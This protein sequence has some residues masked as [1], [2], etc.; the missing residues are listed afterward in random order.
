[1]IYLLQTASPL[2]LEHDSVIYFRIAMGLLNVA[3][4]PSTGYPVGYPALLAALDRA[5]ISSPA[6][7][8]LT[9]CI[10]IAMGLA[11]LSMLFPNARRVTR[12][13]IIILSL[14]SYPMIRSAAMPLTEAAYFGVSMASVL[15]MTLAIRRRGPTAVALLICAGFLAAAAVSIRAIGV[16]LAPALLC[17]AW[18][19]LAQ[20]STK[21]AAGWISKVTL[22]TA[23]CGVATAFILS[24]SGAIQRYKDVVRSS[25]SDPIPQA[26]KQGVQALKNLGE[27]AINLPAERVVLPRGALLLAG[28]VAASLLAWSVAGRQLTPAGAYALTYAGLLFIWPGFDVRLWTPIIPLF[29]AALVLWMSKSRVRLLIAAPAAA[30]FVLTGIAALGWLS[31]QSLAGARFAEIYN[32]MVKPGFEDRNPTHND[33]VAMILV[34]YDPQQARARGIEGR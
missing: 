14:L 28:V 25:W 2:R 16:A 6:V 7:V 8:V 33:D 9:N 10:F 11:A 29:V 13:W 3:P 24:D 27:A 18:L 17:T 23:L 1:L 15:A 4:P 26:R 30:W 12:L 5:G 34:R 19:L 31:L 21:A 22:V 32:P 20:W